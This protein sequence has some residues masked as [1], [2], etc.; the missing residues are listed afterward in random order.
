MHT[1]SWNIRLNICLCMAYCRPWSMKTKH[2]KAFS[3]GEPMP[4]VSKILAIFPCR[5]FVNIVKQNTNLDVKHTDV[6][7]AASHRF[8]CPVFLFHL[9]AFPCWLPLF[10]LHSIWATSF[11]HFP[12]SFPI[13]LTISSLLLTIFLVYST[14]TH[15]EL[16]C[17]RHLHL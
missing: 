2:Q 15:H 8:C 7:W 5:F 6:I 14:F 16:P 11:S 9:P 12:S 10:H 4:K 17:S 13:S 3:T 1:F